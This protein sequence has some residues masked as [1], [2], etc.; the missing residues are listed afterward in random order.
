MIGKG[1]SLR[2]GRKLSI[3]AENVS[4]KEKCPTEMAIGT[5]KGSTKAVTLFPSVNNRNNKSVNFFERFLIIG[6]PP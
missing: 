4:R 6:S 3:G 5:R 1:D 2:P